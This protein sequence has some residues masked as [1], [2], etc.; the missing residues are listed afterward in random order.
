MKFHNWQI[1]A[2]RTSEPDWYGDLDDD[3]AAKWA[4]FLLRAEWMDDNIWW[5]AV[6]VLET[7]EEL[8][9]SNNYENYEPATGLEA[10]RIAE[11]AV[12]ELLGIRK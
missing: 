8:D 5:W 1:E 4:G 12:Y 3:C 2:A 11:S 7:F 6:S 10:R 9:S